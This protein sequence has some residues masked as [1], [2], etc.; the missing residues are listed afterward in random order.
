MSIWYKEGD[1]NK[2]KSKTFRLSRTQIEYMEYNFSKIRNKNESDVKIE[3]HEVSKNNHF[4]IMNWLFIRI[5]R[6]KR[7]LSIWLKLV[8]KNEI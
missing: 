6:L 8:G 3:D 1:W 4:S 2:T 5:E 7:V